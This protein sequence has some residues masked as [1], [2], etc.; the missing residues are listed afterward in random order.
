ME[1]ID[2]KNYKIEFWGGEPLL[3]IDTIYKICEKFKGKVG[4]FQIITNGLLLTKEIIL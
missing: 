1:K 3:Y 4:Y 2:L